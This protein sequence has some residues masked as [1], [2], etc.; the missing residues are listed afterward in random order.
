[1]TSVRR[2]WTILGLAAALIGLTPAHS[3][4]QDDEPQTWHACRVP[5]V[6]VLYMIKES[7]L[8]QECLVPEHVEFSWTEAGEGPAGPQGEAG[9]A[10]PQGEPGPTGPQGPAGE[11]GVDL[12]DIFAAGGQID[13]A[14]G[15]S[16]TATA[17][18]PEGR[19]PV[20]GSFSAGFLQVYSAGVQLGIYNR[21]TASARNT[22]A[23]TQTLYVSANCVVSPVN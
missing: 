9:P 22:V 5:E 10:G 2:V 14:P 7:G 13:I 12:E 15:E 8:P 19:R 16:G 6:G 4:A 1:M 11:S 21:F 18:C 23:S 17:D 20:S 3:S